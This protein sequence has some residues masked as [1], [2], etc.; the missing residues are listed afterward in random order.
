MYQI[1]VPKIKNYSAFN[2]LGQHIGIFVNILNVSLEA[3]FL[4]VPQ[5]GPVADILFLPSF[6]STECF[7]FMFA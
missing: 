5:V 6:C 1:L 2:T 7:I 4:A 3:N